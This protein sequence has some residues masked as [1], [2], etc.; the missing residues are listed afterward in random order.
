MALSGIQRAA[1]VHTQKIIDFIVNSRVED[2]SSKVRRVAR[3]AILDCLGVAVAGALEPAGEIAAAYV[4]DAVGAEHATVW[5][6][7]FRT[8]ARDAAM[9]NGTAAHAL[10]YDDVTWGLIGHP[11]VSLTA[12]LFALGEQ[13]GKSGRDVLH[14]YVVGFEVMAKIGRTTQPLHSLEGNWH[15]TITIGSFG[16]AAACCKLLGLDA[17][18]VG[19]AL[20]MAYSMTSGNT[21]NF[22]TMTK[23]LHAGLAARNGV[24][25]ALLARRGF[26]AVPHPFD[27]P[28]SFHN[29]YSRGLPVDMAPLDELGKLWELDVRGVVIK[30]YPCCVSGHT[31][32]DAALRLRQEDGA[33]PDDI[34]GIELGVTKY[35][36]DK[37]SYHR[38]VTGLEGKFSAHYAV[39][40]AI[41]DGQLGL[42]T[43]TDPAVRDAQIV[44]LVARIRMAVDDEIERAWKIGSRP[45]KLK[46]TFTD[47]R[48][49]EKV[50]EISKGNPEVPLTEAEL[51]A[52]FRDCTGLVLS[53]AAVERL[54]TAL[55]NIEDVP[56]VSLITDLLAGA[57]TPVRH[58]A[59][60]AV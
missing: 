8:S 1:P 43:F 29:T 4:R 24:E 48:I 27:G 44:E 50:V 58:E 35:T 39:A 40:R 16:A 6:Q 47:G 37:L 41:T 36:Y 51:L 53:Q 10:D 32:I 23:P 56:D 19:N 55:T 5:G 46:A 45:V 3:E 21:S 52:K 25:A 20:G 9:V 31:S 38:P 34:A 26:N 12:S 22:G 30:P 2:L 49:V 42:A 57:E 15:A 13:F 18:A 14:A 11:S 59:G 60:A 7:G 33:R 28:K 54:V 17:E